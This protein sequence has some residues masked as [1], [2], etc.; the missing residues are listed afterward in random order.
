M[1]SQSARKPPN[2]W[3]LASVTYGVVIVVTLLSILAYYYVVPKR[4]DPLF[5][6]AV[7][8]MAVGSVWIP[9][10]PGAML[11]GTA[12]AKQDRATESTLTFETKDQGDRV[13][14]FYQ[15]VLKKGAFRF[16]TVT[17]SAGGGTVRSMAHEGKTTVVVTIHAAG[18]GSEGEVRTIDRDTGDKDTRN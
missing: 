6:D 4:T 17:K 12:S 14:S 8:S 2:I 7:R 18:E 10:Y 13:L 5:G 15:A 9:V 11:E 1:M 3:A 16:E